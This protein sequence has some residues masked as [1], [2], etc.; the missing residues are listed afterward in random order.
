[1]CWVGGIFYPFPFRIGLKYFHLDPQDFCH[2]FHFCHNHLPFKPICLSFFCT[3]FFPL[4]FYH[5]A[6]L[7]PLAPKKHYFIGKNSASLF[8]S[9]PPGLSDIPIIALTHVKLLYQTSDFFHACQQHLIRS[10]LL[11]HLVK[12]NVLPTYI[13][14][15]EINSK[16]CK[17]FSRVSLKIMIFRE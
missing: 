12:P 9:F 2:F 14:F 6:D 13:Q 17:M 3:F 11:L 5:L 8:P 15:F 10:M 4:S 7:S 1:M 16:I